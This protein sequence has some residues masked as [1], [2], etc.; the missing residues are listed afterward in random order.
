[1][2]NPTPIPLEGS[3]QEDSQGN[4]KPTWPKTP[5]IVKVRPYKLNRSLYEWLEWDGKMYHRTMPLMS[6]GT[7]TVETQN[8]FRHGGPFQFTYEGD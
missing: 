7:V 5:F 6:Y 4:A 1:V 8:L 2:S 3:S